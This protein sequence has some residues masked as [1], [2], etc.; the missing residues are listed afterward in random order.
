M[1]KLMRGAVDPYGI[2]LVLV[3]IGTFFFEAKQHGQEQQEYSQSITNSNKVIAG[4]TT[5]ASDK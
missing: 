4:E 5:D 1:K 2:S 3:I